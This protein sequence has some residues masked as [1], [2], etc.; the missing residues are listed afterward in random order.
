MTNFAHVWLGACRQQLQRKCI[1]LYAAYWWNAYSCTGDLDDLVSQKR[2]NKTLN[3]LAFFLHSTGGCFYT[4]SQ[5][6]LNS[7]NT[8]T[9]YIYNVSSSHCRLSC[10]TDSSC[11][12]ITWTLNSTTATRN[13]T[14]YNHSSSNGTWQYYVTVTYSALSKSFVACGGNFV[15][16]NS[17]QKIDFP[18]R[19]SCF[20]QSWWIKWDRNS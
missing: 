10:A 16:S 18:N 9:S 19:R 1:E 12:G 3:N 13:C 14:L 11:T 20:A 6:T 7:N 4:F 15:L 5:A 8:P 17:K 2:L